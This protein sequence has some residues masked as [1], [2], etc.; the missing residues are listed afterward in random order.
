MRGRKPTPTVQL[1]LSGSW[2][3]KARKNEPQPELGAPPKPEWLT[4][5]GAEC[6]D[7]LVGILKPMRVLSHADALALVQMAEYL[8]RWRKATASISKYGDLY[9]VKDDKGQ[10]KSMKRSP[11]V[12]LQTSYGEVL[13]R[14][15]AEFGMTPSSRARVHA[16]GESAT[17]DNMFSR[18]KAI[19]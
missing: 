4:E 5:E 18:V 6:W 15:M 11:H 1:K 16:G 3:G 2:R 10:I 12:S 14:F 8:A 9:P 7:F 19:G 17:S 13:Y